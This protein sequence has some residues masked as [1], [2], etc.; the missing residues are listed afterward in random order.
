MKYTVSQFHNHVQWL[1]VTNSGWS[2]DNQTWQKEWKTAQLAK[3]QLC[4]YENQTLEAF[5]AASC[6]SAKFDCPMAHHNFSLLATAHD[7]ETGLVT[8]SQKSFT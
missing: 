5:V 8:K 6:L 2:L 7:C 1:K 3:V 4:E